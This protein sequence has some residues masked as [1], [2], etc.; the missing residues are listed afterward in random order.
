LIRGGR[1]KE[2][3]LAGEPARTFVS[4]HSFFIL[5]NR[6]FWGKEKRMGREKVPEKRV[7]EE[8]EE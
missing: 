8:K 2:K 4:L 7:D 3:V 6:D 1:S 5:S